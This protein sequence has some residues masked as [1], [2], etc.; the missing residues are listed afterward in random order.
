MRFFEQPQT[1][2][3]SSKIGGNGVS[4]QHEK[5]TLARTRDRASHRLLLFVHAVENRL[6]QPLP[7]LGTLVY[8]FQQLSGA[9]NADISDAE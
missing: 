2:G 7:A 1:C 3:R 8:R 4:S 5:L 6:P 9:S